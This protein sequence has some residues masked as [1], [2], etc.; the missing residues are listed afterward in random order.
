MQASHWRT[1][2]KKWLYP[3]GFV[4]SH[5]SNT[6]TLSK[7]SWHILLADQKEVKFLECWQKV[8]E[9]AYQE[10]EKIKI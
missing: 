9:T 5:Q 10:L 7:T 4:K 8:K 2:L 3:F 6:I 1:D